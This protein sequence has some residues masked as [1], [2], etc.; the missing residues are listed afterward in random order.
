MKQGDVCIFINGS[1]AKLLTAYEISPGQFLIGKIITRNVRE[2]KVENDY[3]KIYYHDGV[4]ETYCFL[5]GIDAWKFEGKNINLNVPST[6]A[7]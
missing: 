4:I 3:L 5:E 1:P 7:N 2:A 6:S